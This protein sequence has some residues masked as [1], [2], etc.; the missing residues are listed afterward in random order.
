M[1]EVEVKQ[2][3]QRFYKEHKSFYSNKNHPYKKQ[4][5]NKQDEIQW[6]VI[7][8][9]KNNSK[10]EAQLKQINQVHIIL[11]MFVP[12]VL[13]KLMRSNY[14]RLSFHFWLRY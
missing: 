4:Q 9:K 8:V 13:L 2:M 5:S 10:Q 6:N 11:E 1:G 7:C 14:N 3:K 12:I